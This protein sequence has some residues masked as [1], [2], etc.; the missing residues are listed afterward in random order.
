MRIKLIIV[1]CG[2]FMYS[3][4]FLNMKFKLTLYMSSSALRWNRK[5]Q[6]RATTCRQSSRVI[7]RH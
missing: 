1:T 3:F 7:L 6:L 5:E 4:L 2:F